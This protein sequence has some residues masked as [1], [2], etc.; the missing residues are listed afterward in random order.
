MHVNPCTKTKKKGGRGGDF[1]HLIALTTVQHCLNMCS[2]SLEP[3]REK[4]KK[5]I[6]CRSLSAVFFVCMCMCA[7]DH[8]LTSN[9]EQNTSCENKSPTAATHDH[10]QDTDGVQSEKKNC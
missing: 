9:K 10:A 2:K 4:K 3:E 1:Q 5:N 7:I 8:C 6:L